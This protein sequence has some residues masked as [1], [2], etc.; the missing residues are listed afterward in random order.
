[1]QSIEQ[2]ENTRHSLPLLHLWSFIQ[3]LKLCMLWIKLFS[4]FPRVLF[5][6]HN[7]LSI[8]QPFSPEPPH[9][10]NNGPRCGKWAKHAQAAGP[11]ILNPGVARLTLDEPPNLL[12]KCGA[13][14]KTRSPRARHFVPLFPHSRELTPSISNILRRWGGFDFVRNAFRL[15]HLPDEM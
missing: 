8:P 15:R 12:S 13:P 10:I 4:L 5:S 3:Y 9:P 2:D 1:M 11:H 14:L 6:A 7:L